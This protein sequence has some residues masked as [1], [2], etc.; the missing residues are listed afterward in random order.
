M[1]Q[2]HAIA[3]GEDDVFDKVFQPEEALTSASFSGIAL[4]NCVLASLRY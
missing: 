3:P 1:V 4:L 2:R